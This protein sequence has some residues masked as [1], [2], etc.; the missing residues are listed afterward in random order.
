MA[1]EVPLEADR[2]GDL[3][4]FSAII[5]APVFVVGTV[6]WAFGRKK[7]DEDEDEEP[8]LMEGNTSDDQENRSSMNSGALKQTDPSLQSLIASEVSE[9]EVGESLRAMCLD[10]TVSKPKKELSWSDYSGMQ[11]TEVIGKEVSKEFV[12]FV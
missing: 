11:L 5:R 8:T 10:N 2:V 6:F 9:L 4:L 7:D 3:N 1:F 12:V